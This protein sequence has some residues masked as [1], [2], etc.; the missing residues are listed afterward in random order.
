MAAKRPAEKD[1]LRVSV[2]N[3]QVETNNKSFALNKKG[4]SFFFG[5][6]T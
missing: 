1:V 2:P 6:M 3:D 5:A 4:I